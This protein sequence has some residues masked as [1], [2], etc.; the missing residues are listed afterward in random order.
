MRLGLGF[1]ATGF[2]VQGHLVVRLRVD[3]LEDVDLACRASMSA[4]SSEARGFLGSPS[5]GQFGP[6]IQKAGQTLHP[7][8]ACTASRM[9]IEFFILSYQSGCCFAFELRITL[10]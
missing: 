10:Y 5:L 4:D 7:N 6:N 1:R 3:T 2:G 8:G 9:T